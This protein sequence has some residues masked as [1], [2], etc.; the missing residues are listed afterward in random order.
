MRLLTH[1]TLRN[2]TKEAKG[3]EFPLKITAVEIRVEEND[4]EITEQQ[5]NFVK[6]MLTR[7]DWPALVQVRN[8][9]GVFESPLPG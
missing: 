1:N 2:N 8:G 4:T 6:N 9:F 7:I 3:K 5:I